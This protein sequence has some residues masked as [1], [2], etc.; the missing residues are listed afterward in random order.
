MTLGAVECRGYKAFH[1]STR[2]N[3]RRLTIVF[4]K[5]NSGKTTLARLPIFATASLI[6]KQLVTL[7]SRDVSFG[8]SFS[9]LTSSDD[10]HP[11]LFIKVTLEDGKS[12]A[13][14]LQRVTTYHPHE[15]IQPL[16][17]TI[18]DTIEA[19]RKLSEVAIRAPEGALVDSLRGQ[20]KR[21]FANRVRELKRINDT[22][23]HIPGA[24]PR[25]VPAYSMREP[26]DNTAEEAVYMLA[27]DS[28]LQSR[29]DR[30]FVDHVDDT[31]IVV[32][33]AAFAFQL[34]T[35]RQEGAVNL[36]HSGRGTQ[37]LLPVVTLLLANISTQTPASMIALE[38]PEEHMHPSA[39]GAI[40][41][42]LISASERSKV[43]VETHSENLILRLRRRI[44]ERMLSPDDLSLY[45]V[46]EW[47][48]VI[49]I[50]VTADGIPTNWPVGV[51]ESD[52]TEAQAIIEAR[53]SAMKGLR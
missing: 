19:E 37:S 3:M 14:Q 53:M 36:A 10:P 43:I 20:D 26:V 17:L 5:N 40:A 48:N 41:D 18:D 16:R 46:D 4:G 44:A 30:W 24:R 6:N 51:F 47:H 52:V 23:I 45:Y 15:V 39:H 2:L 1:G 42:L 12:L 22:T 38:E 35:I 49:P 7:R 11:S 29:V 34:L 9:D 8:S 50:E 25:I 28:D 31:R 13:V 21:R 27:N 33:R 32:D